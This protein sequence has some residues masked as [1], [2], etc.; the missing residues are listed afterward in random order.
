MKLRTNPSL[1][2]NTSTL[3]YSQIREGSAINREASLR[4]ANDISAAIDR[5]AREFKWGSSLF[6]GGLAFASAYFMAKATSEMTASALVRE[7][8]KQ[9]KKEARQAPKP[10]HRLNETA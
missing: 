7:Q 2:I 10:P 6:I 3:Q 9:A 5:D 1:P 4:M 8:K